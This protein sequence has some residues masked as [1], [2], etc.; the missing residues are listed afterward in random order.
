[1]HV[2]AKSF[3]SITNIKRTRLQ[4][5][6]K[7]WQLNSTLRTEKRGGR[8][9]SK[10][11]EELKE[12]IR[13]H[14]CSFKCRDS[15]YSR[16]NANCRKYLP[17]DISIRRMWRL[18][19]RDNDNIACNFSLYYK[20][21]RS[22]F[23]L[24]FG[25]PRSDICGICEK[26]RLKIKLCQDPAEKVT[27]MTDFNLHKRRAKYFYTLL[28]RVD[29]EEPSIT[30]AF[31]MQQNQPLPKV[32]VGEAFYARQIWVF[33]LTF[34]VHADN[35]QPKE[36]VHIYTWDETQAGR[37]SNTVASALLHFL[38]NLDIPEGIM[39][40]RLFSDACASQNRNSTV[41][42]ACHYFCSVVKPGFII[43]H[44]FP[45]RGHS[46]LP[47]DRVFGRMEKVLRRLEV[48]LLPSDYHKIY[49]DFGIVYVL[50]SDWELKDCKAQVKKLFKANLGFKISQVKVIRFESNKIGVKSLY[51]GEFCYHNI[52]KK[53]KK[54]NAFNP[55]VISLK[56]CITQVKAADVMK[57]LTSAGVEPS[58]TPE[59]V[60][61]YDCVA[62]TAM[63]CTASGSG[64]PEPDEDENIVAHFDDDDDAVLR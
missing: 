45:I 5:I 11:R 28:N 56:S 10:L 32:A 52:G 1:V 4:N 60:R 35:T 38:V 16:N 7:E 47:A 26:L 15:H 44:H 46:F 41:V 27:L 57:L 17:P 49:Q 14:I 36:K 55:E 6:A 25:N 2:C 13:S 33:N 39:K 51:N 62:E 43:E 63:Q 58:S 23:N 61:F 12:K 20:I 22:E 50:G 64:E 59:L 24:G 37:D 19:K 34:V 53:G 31:D 48:L 42:G 8:R 54:I 3:S 9:V 29:Y 40:L 18:F 21:F 30:V